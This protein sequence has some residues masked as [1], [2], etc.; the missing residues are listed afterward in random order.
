MRNKRIMIPVL[1]AVFL[2]AGAGTVFVMMKIKQTT[3]EEPQQT[4]ETAAAEEEAK[5]TTTTEETAEGEKK[6]ETQTPTTPEEQNQ[7]AVEKQRACNVLREQMNAEI[8][9]EDSDYNIAHQKAGQCNGGDCAA[10]A[11][12]VE[13][14]HNVNLGKIR[15]TYQQKWTYYSCPGIL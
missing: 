2:L 12:K 8:R 9:K 4:E 15:E 1:V 3:P 10:A 6:E 14:D 11:A 13:T 7:K 5:E